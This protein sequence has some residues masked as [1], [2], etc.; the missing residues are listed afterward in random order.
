MSEILAKYAGNKSAKS[1]LRHY[2]EFAAV[3]HTEPQS[4][5]SDARSHKAADVQAQSP[6]SPDL[7]EEQ[8]TRRI[9]IDCNCNAAGH[10]WIIF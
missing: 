3:A 7:E 2:S 8:Q 4:L 5:R 1:S 9:T 6:W 10:S